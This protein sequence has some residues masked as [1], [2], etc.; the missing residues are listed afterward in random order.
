MLLNGN[1]H[2]NA[3]VDDCKS[4]LRRLGAPVLQHCFREQNQVADAMA[5]RA[6]SGNFERL[7]TFVVP[8]AAC[9][10][11]ITLILF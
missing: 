6:T 1:L 10:C 9:S 2:Y 4:R 11:S 3:S 5:K 8:P 7:K